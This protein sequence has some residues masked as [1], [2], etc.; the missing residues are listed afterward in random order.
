MLCSKPSDSA[1]VGEV[2]ELIERVGALDAC[3]RLAH[4]QVERAWSRLDPVLD[5]SQVKLTFRAFAWF[6]LDRHY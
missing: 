2:I 5:D 3:S 4:E 6:V 1:V